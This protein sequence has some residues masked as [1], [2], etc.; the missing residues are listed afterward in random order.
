MVITLGWSMSLVSSTP[1]SYIYPRRAI[2]ENSFFVCTR[3]MVYWNNQLNLPI[4]LPTGF[5]FCFYSICIVVREWL[6]FIGTDWLQPLKVWLY[7]I[8]VSYF[9][10]VS[11]LA[12]QLWPVYGARLGMIQS[13]IKYVVFLYICSFFVCAHASSIFTTG[14]LRRLQVLTPRTVAARAQL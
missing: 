8:N 1:S 10:L 6:K 4:T 3:R 5:L 2:N 13:N 14:V 11:G 9:L 12:C 7:V